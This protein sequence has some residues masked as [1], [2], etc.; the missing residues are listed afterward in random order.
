[1]FLF[2]ILPRLVRPYISKNSPNI[3]KTQ[4]CDKLR[5]GVFF[6]NVFFNYKIV[7]VINI[8]DHRISKIILNIYVIV[9]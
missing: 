6:Y 9:L 2:C 4:K 3:Y 8:T 1:M 5:K 7:N